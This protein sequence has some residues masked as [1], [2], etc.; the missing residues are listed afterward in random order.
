MSRF[1]AM[2]L[3]ARGFTPR[4]LVLRDLGLHGVRQGG[5]LLD[6]SC[7][8]VVMSDDS[9]LG[10]F[11]DDFFLDDDDLALLAEGIMVDRPGRAYSNRYCG[12]RLSRLQRGRLRANLRLLY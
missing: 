5:L 8:I 9:R 11:D 10:L 12:R 3:S 2:R 7:T 1:G 6:G 4:G